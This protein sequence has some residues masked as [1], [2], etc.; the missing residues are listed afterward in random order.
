MALQDGEKSFGMTFFL[1]RDDRPDYA[2]YALVVLFTRSVN[3]I[4]SDKV[5]TTRKPTS[6]SAYGDIAPP[7]PEERTRQS[8][9]E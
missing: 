9:S 2:P 5:R 6:S 8:A 4:Y 7:S 1:F 3:F